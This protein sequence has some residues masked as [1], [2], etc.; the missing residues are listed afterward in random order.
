[1]TSKNKIVQLHGNLLNSLK[2]KDNTTIGK[3][4]A[5]LKQALSQPNETTGL[6]EEQLSEI[7]Q[8]YFEA[9][10][11]SSVMRN[12]MDGFKEAIADVHSFYGTQTKESAKKYLMIGLHLM[13]LLV[14]NRLADFHMLLEQVDQSVQQKDPYIFTPVQL[15]QSLNEGAYNKV[16]LNEKNLP[17]PY[18]SIFVQILMDTV[19][20]EISLCLEKS[21][22]SLSIKD[23]ARMLLYENEKDLMTFAQ[24]KHWRLANKEFIF[25]SE[26][27]DA[28]SRNTLDTVRLAKQNIFYAKQLEMIV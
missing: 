28:A 15:E 3:V 1:M 27:P 10:A 21:Y 6:K 16:I 11:L 12:D 8:D 19:R 14:T 24:Q 4:L 23:A 13:Y 17:S 25:G 7:L 5:D 18:Y 22:K 26:L 2:N 9:T 20:N